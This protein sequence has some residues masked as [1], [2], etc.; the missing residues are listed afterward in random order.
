[1]LVGEDDRRR[2][3]DFSEM[4]GATRAPHAHRAAGRAESLPLRPRRIAAAASTAAGKAADLRVFARVTRL[5]SC[6]WMR[7]HRPL[8]SLLIWCVQALPA[9]SAHRRLAGSCC[10]GYLPGYLSVLAAL[11]Y[12][13][14]AVG[15][16]SRSRSAALAPRRLRF[17]V[18]ALSARL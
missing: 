17:D 4:F 11:V 6:G 1:M 2:T 16:A 10:L 7:Y 14:A 8:R 15:V 12:V 18:Q 3:A 9:G 13:G 5:C